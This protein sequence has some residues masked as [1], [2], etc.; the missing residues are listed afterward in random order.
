VVN[1]E[2]PIDTSTCR[3]APGLFAP[4][5]DRNRCEGKAQC[6]TVC[7]NDV[8]V[9]GVLPKSERHAL[10]LMGKVKGLAH[11]WKQALVPNI[12]ACEACGLCV[13]ACPEEAIK[14]TRT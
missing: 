3:Q 10:S 7:P 11:G 6:V 8:F 12:A 2:R 1:K 14:L 4:L 9:I 13:S 5:I